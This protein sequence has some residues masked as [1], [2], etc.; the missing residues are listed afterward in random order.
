MEHVMVRVRDVQLQESSRRKR[1]R[2]ARNRRE[3]RRRKEA[4]L[5]DE[6]PGNG[7]EQ[8]PADNLVTSEAWDP[9]S[10]PTHDWTPPESEE[11]PTWTQKGG[12]PEDE[13]PVRRL[14]SEG[15]RTR[16][17]EI[18]PVDERR[19]RFPPKPLMPQAELARLRR[20]EKQ[21]MSD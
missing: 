7:P 13:Q 9:I 4:A 16:T 3:K 14:S 21:V 10:I 6:T 15:A 18:P 8:W 5:A 11:V 17:E 2:K 12:N 1:E 20:R 19:G